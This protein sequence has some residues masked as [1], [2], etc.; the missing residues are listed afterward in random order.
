MAEKWKRLVPVPVLLVCL[1]MCLPAGVRGDSLTT[2]GKHVQPAAGTPYNGYTLFNANGDYNSNLIDMAGTTVH[3]WYNSRRGGYSVYL[4]ENGNLMRPGE[5]PSAIMKGAAFSG[6]LQEI[7]WDA[8]VVW[9]FKY[10][11]AT[12]NMHHDIK[13]MPNGNILLIAW[14]KKTAS[15]VNGAGYRSSTEM[16]VDSIIEV[17]RTASA[18]QWEWH[19][20]DHLIQD[21]NSGKANYGIV[22][23]HPELLDINLA[24]VGSGPAGYDWLHLNSVSYNP[25]LDRIIVSSHTNDEIYVIDH[26]TTTLEAKGHTGGNSGKGGDILYRWGKPSNYRASGATTL[27]V[28][29]C[30][31]WI[32]QGLPGAGH[33]MVFNNGDKTKQSQVLEL[34]PVRE[35]NGSYQFTPGT[36]YGPWSPAWSYSDGTSFYSIHLGSN[37]RLPNGNTLISESTANHLLEVDSAGSIVWEFTYAKQIARSLRYAP[38]YPG[39]SKLVPDV[40]IV[41]VPLALASFLWL[42]AVNTCP[43]RKTKNISS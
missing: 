21:I 22:A 16:W 30:S 25:E 34:D 27:D 1:I 20:W 10:S 13:P 3:T 15:E 41:I 43:G 39:L 18:I 12:Y 26:S 36:G 8:N 28:C 14:D 42:F 29:H 6:L 33:I 11:S 2:S 40:P 35:A 17:N 38:S 24:N 4:L 9:E 23:N 7:D 37:Q 31:V 19:A 32:E 5:D